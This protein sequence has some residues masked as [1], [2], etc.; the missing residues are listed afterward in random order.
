VSTPTT[1]LPQPSA[2]RSSLHDRGQRLTPQRQRVLALF[3][4]IGAGSH[5]SAEEVHQRLLR[6]S[7]RVSLATVYR[8][9]RLLSSMGLLQEL[10]L[11]EGGRRFELASDAHRDHHHLVCVRCG[12][13]EEFES[14]AVLA[15]GEA[16]AGV[17][18]FRLLECVLNVRAL[19]P[20]CSAAERV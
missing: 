7:E 8:T 2:L 18:G 12:R 19:C 10:E 14:L 9:L 16:A 20:G 5:L 1:G 4:R 13:T 11:P 15:A 17:H 3:E 6:G